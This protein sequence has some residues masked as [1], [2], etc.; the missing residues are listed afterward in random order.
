MSIYPN[1]SFKYISFKNNYL[2]NKYKNITFQNNKSLVYIELIFSNE[3][4][5][6]LILKLRLFFIEE[7]F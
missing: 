3:K 1:N 7:F 5:D 6:E 4:F 2:K